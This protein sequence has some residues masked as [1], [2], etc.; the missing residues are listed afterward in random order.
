MDGIISEIWVYPVKSLGGFRSKRAWAAEKGF[1]HDRRWMLV[2]A[3]KKFI[4]QREMPAMTQF[5]TAIEDQS[6]IISNRTDGTSVTLSAQP[7]TGEAVTVAIWND[8]V[9]AIIP[10]LSVNQW[11]SHFL[12]SP[13]QLVYMP[14]STVRQT[15]PRF[16]TP[17]D[18]VSFADGFP[19]LIISEGSLANL[20]EKLE[21][22]VPMNRFRPNLVLSGVSPFE[23]DRHAEMNAGDL[24]FRLVKPCARCPIPTTDQL[25]G[26]RGPEPLRTLATFRRQ[27]EKVVFGQNALVNEP[28]WLK[29]GTA[30]QW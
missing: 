21:K 15:D 29:E 27:N 10:D 4:T 18:Q 5:Q 7:L 8:T 14:E 16:S 3:E 23:E 24:K 30:I 17:T 12:G 6:L 1:R 11:F 22:A 20:N 19:Y 13:C 9:E 25:T 28:G 2:D 26:E